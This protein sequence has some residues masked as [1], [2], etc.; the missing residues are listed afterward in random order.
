MT[1]IYKK[2]KL[3]L[4]KIKKNVKKLRFYGCK[5]EAYGVQKRIRKKNLQTK[6]TVPFVPLRF[7]F[8]SIEA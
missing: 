6:I 5:V 2:Y 8:T 3:L 4:I 1:M 7:Y